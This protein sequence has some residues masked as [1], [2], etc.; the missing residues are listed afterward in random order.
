[1]NGGQLSARVSTSEAGEW[2]CAVIRSPWLVTTS[3]FGETL[4]CITA[5]Y[6]QLERSLIAEEGARR[7]GACQEAG[8]TRWTTHARPAS[9]GEPVATWLSKGSVLATMPPHFVIVRKSGELTI[10]E[11]ARILAI[12]RFTVRR[13][14]REGR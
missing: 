11:A 1:M 8:D 4:Y 2:T 14:Q 10:R 3:P 7:H 5:A 6:A 9:R 12:G 13:L